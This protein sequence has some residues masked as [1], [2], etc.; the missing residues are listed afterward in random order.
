MADSRRPVIVGVGQIAGKDPDRIVHPVELIAEAVGLAVDDA[1]TGPAILDRVG[2]VLSS[3]ISVF[4]DDDAAELV[5]ARL[6]LPGRRTYESTYSG[7]GPQRMVAEASRRIAA[8]EIDAAVVVGGIAD[9]SVKRARSR[10]EEPPAPPTAS[11]SQGSRAGLPLPRLKPGVHPGPNAEMGAGCMAPVHFFAL[12]ESAFAAAAGRPPAEQRAF[13]GQLMAPFTEVA[14]G[15]AE[16]AWFP[17][18]RSAGEIATPSE[19][20]RL[21]AEPYTKLMCSF[22]TVD[23]AAAV[24]MC[25]EDVADRLRVP[26][27]RRVHPWSVAAV[28]DPVAP[29]RWPRM[30]RSPGM[31]L[32]ADTALAAAGVDPDRLGALDLYSCFPAAVQLGLAALGISTGDRRT[33]TVT[34]GLPY[35]GGPGASYS[36]HGLATMVDRCR[37]EPSLVAGIVGIGGMANDSSVG[38]YSATPIVDGSPDAARTAH[39]ARFLELDP[40][41]RDRVPIV[42]TADGEAEVVAMTVLHGPD[43]RVEAAPLV[44]RLA[45]GS[46][47]GARAASPELV[48]ELAGTSLVGRRVRLATAG[49][50]S[51]YEPA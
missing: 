35:F 29:S 46:R 6:D 1:R 17:T 38:V 45:D 48:A 44:A 18:A 24:L 50:H 43:L 27:E 30:D 21:V 23:L 41:D 3:P 20:N 15:N 37:A 39:D 11:W 12:I 51:T 19:G 5:S 22:P 7:A 33:F 32:A 28:K 25:A 40:P 26:A 42:H 47:V 8:G 31:Q 14:A 34:G 13:L 9:A 16:L 49:D 4:S 36:L 2:L 10:G